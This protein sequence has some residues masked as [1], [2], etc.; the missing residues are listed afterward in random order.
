[1]SKK[2]GVKR[3]L[4]RA[5]HTSLPYLTLRAYAQVKTTALVTVQ[6]TKDKVGISP[7]GMGSPALRLLLLGLGRYPTQVISRVR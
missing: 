7:T 4:T 3:L 5:P 6:V 2:S 1:M